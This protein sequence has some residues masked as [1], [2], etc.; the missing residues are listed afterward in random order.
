MLKLFLP[1]DGAISG[2]EVLCEFVSEGT[3]RVVSA[4]FC[5]NEVVPGDIVKFVDGKIIEVLENVNHLI[6]VFCDAETEELA[7]ALKTHNIRVEPLG[8]FETFRYGLVVP[9]SVTD[10]ELEGILEGLPWT[11]TWKRS[12]T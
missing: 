1:Y 3:A 6:Y 12:T 4:L 10:A 7:E 2:E 11:I 8:K 5:G 9:N